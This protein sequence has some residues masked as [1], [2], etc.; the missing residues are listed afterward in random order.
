MSNMNEK[1]YELT[2]II[3][4]AYKVSRNELDYYVTD[5]LSLAYQLRIEDVVKKLKLNIKYFNNGERKV[6]CI[7]KEEIQDVISPIQV[8]KVNTF[9]S[10][11][12]S[13]VMGS[14]LGI[15]IKRSVLGN[16]YCNENDI[17]FEILG[18]IEKYVLDNFCK[19]GSKTIEITKLDRPIKEKEKLKKEIIVSSLRLDSLVS[20]VFKVSRD[21]AKS[22]IANKEVEYN[23]SIPSRVDLKVVPPCYVSTRGKGK[24][25]VKS[26]L[27][28]T[29]SD[30]IVLECEIF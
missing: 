8:Y 19:I 11:K 6:G 26:V 15:G 16:I 3:E 9:F 18:S 12:H 25:F 7:F 24:V 17:E 13:E 22:R 28:Y 1:D 4:H 27:R 21:E 23:F 14:L 2:N 29:R 5:F 10:F 30:R 20:S